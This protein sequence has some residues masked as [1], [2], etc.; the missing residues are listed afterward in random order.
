[1]AIPN[2]YLVSMRFT[3][4]LICSTTLQMSNRTKHIRYKK[5]VLR[6]VN[7]CLESIITYFQETTTVRE[8]AIPNQYQLSMWF[9]KLPMAVQNVEQ[10][11]CGTSRTDG[12][13]FRINISCL[14]GLQN[15]RWQ[16]KCRTEPLWN[17]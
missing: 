9:T 2:Q 16:Y 14:C 11:H 17:I 13:Q 10:S 1:M 6:D 15:R 3:K 5:Q 12:L 8:F 7:L 4:P